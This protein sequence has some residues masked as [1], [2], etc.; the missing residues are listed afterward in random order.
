MIATRLFLL[1]CLCAVAACDNRTP[2]P[3]PELASTA[4][5]EQT[6][7]GPAARDD[8]GERAV[9]PDRQSARDRPTNTRDVGAASLSPVDRIF[10]AESAALG[11]AEVAAARL[12]LERAADPKVKDFARHMIREHEQTNEELDRIAAD[13]GIAIVPEARGKPSD[14]LERLKRL[15]GEEFDSFYVKRFGFEAHRNAI[16]LYERQNRE[17]RDANLKA[18]AEKALPDERDHEAMAEYLVVMAAR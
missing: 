14:D 18:F 17:G 6:A 16:L 4:D 11:L 5:R 12:A 10:L 2:V 7:G 9:T 8:A 1:A 15:S 13:K 3:P